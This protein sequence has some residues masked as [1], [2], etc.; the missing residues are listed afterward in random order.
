MKSI[1]KLCAFTFFNNIEKYISTS[2]E[3]KVGILY[4]R[5]TVGTSF[6]LHLEA[7]WFWKFGAI[8]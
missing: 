2:H 3:S 4:S 7:P 1:L 8:I 6:C 5:I